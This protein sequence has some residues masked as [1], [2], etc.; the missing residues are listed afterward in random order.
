MRSFTIESV[1]R[2][3]G[4]KVNHTGGRFESNAKNA[5]DSV[6]RKMFTKAS[7]KSTKSLTISF[8]ETTQGSTGKIFKKKITRVHDP[9]EVNHDGVLVVHEYTTK[10]KSMGITH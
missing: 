6:A 1:H 5:P 7:T 9:V 2:P 10:V 8:R 4:N 3:N